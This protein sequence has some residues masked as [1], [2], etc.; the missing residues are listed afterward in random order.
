MS[1]SIVDLPEHRSTAWWVRTKSDEEAVRQGCYFDFEAA[2][3]VR[4]FARRFIMGTTGEWS[5][6][7]F[8][9]L[10][11]QWFDFVAPLFGWKQADGR[12]RFSRFGVGIPKKN[13]KSTLTAMLCLYMLIA[14]REPNAEVYLCSTNKQQAKI[15][16]REAKKFLDASPRLQRY[17]KARVYWGK[18][19]SKRDSSFLEVLA[20]ENKGKHGYNSHF[21]LFDEFHEQPNWEL[22]NTLRYAGDARRQ[23]IIGWISTQGFDDSRPWA[24][25]WDYCKSLLRGEIIDVSYL[26]VIYETAENED[27]NDERIW[28]KAN[29]SLGHTI[30]LDKMRADFAEAKN[31]G[32][33]ALKDFRI[34]K[35]NQRVKGGGVYIPRES[36]DA[37]TVHGVQVT[38]GECYAALDLAS[39]RDLNALTFVSWHG[40]KLR[41]ESFF[42]CPEVTANKE[43]SNAELYDRWTDA[44]FLKRFPGNFIDWDAVCPYVLE[45]MKPRRPVKVLVDPHNASRLITLLVDAGYEVVPFRQN[46]F[47]YNEPTRELERL[48][49]RGL[50]EHSHNPV[51]SY[52]VGNTEISTDRHG[53]VMPDRSRN[54]LRKIDGVPSTLMGLAELIKTVKQSTEVTEFGTW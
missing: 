3:K 20:S 53:Y 7:P 14:D 27:Y 26:T 4:E 15:V 11:W 40:E 18:F 38:P 48:V 16:Y 39:T 8:E 41:Q 24:S 12:R 23:S 6:Q 30:R 25:E 5:G 33:I 42:W 9:L 2:D 1:S 32:S 37:L 28:A 17:L 36:W 21:T 44:G 10:P 49:H 50:V 13:G 45:T 22:W 47:N 31:K 52:C 51:M 34:L 19:E 43:K 54:R 35:L 46:T 29:P